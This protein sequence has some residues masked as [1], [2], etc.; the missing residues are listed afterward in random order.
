MRKRLLFALVVL[1]ASFG[2]A[3]AAEQTSLNDIR[4]ANAGTES[5]TWNGA[6]PSPPSVEDQFNVLKVR[7][8]TLTQ[9]STE[10][11]RAACF[12]QTMTCRAG[13]GGIDDYAARQLCLR[14]CN[15]AGEACQN[16]CR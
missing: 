8:W 13:C 6:P 11:C 4:L 12:S 14:R 5:Q 1:I 7:P 3:P 9:R 2:Q 10:D 16:R 15:S